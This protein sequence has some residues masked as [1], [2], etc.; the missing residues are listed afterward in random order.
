MIFHASEL[1]G[2]QH[3]RVKCKVLSFCPFKPVTINKDFYRPANIDLR[4][5]IYISKNSGQEEIPF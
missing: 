5:M 3:D 2:A 4:S 1:S